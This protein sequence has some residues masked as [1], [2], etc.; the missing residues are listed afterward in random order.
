MC[1]TRR[2]TQNASR[3]DVFVLTEH[4]TKI[5]KRILTPHSISTKRMYCPKIL[6]T[7]KSKKS[8]LSLYNINS[9]IFISV[10]HNFCTF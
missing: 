7:K 4:K 5:D 8:Y 2:H 10:L 9:E 6:L 1:D 3:D